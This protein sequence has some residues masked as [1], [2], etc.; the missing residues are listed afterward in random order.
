LKPIS[1]F[2]PICVCETSVEINVNLHGLPD[3][4]P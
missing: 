4:L 3:A 1:D 2:T